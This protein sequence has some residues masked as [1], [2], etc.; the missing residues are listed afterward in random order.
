MACPSSGS[1]LR[2]LTGFLFTGGAI[3]LHRPQESRTRRAR[4]IASGLAQE[5]YDSFYPIQMVSYM[6]GR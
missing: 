2:G 4:A 3:L 1:Y 5:I 6:A